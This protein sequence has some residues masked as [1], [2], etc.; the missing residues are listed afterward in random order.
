[1]CVFLCMTNV[2]TMPVVHLSRSKGILVQHTV[3]VCTGE[4][5]L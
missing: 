4:K 5:L 1:M 2:D 3:N